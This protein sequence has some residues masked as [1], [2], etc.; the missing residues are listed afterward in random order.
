MRKL[1]NRGNNGLNWLM[2]NNLHHESQTAVKWQRQLS[3]TYKNQQGVCHGGVLSATLFK[4][5]NNRLLDRIQISGKGAR[6]G[7]I[8]IQAPTCADDMTILTNDASSLQFLDDTCKDSSDMDGYILQEIKSVVMKKDSV[9]NY[10]EGE[11]WQIGE[12]EMPVVENTTHMGILH[13]SSN[14]ERQAFESNIQKAKLTVHSLMGTGLHSEN[15]LDP[16]TAISLLQTYVYPVLYYGL[17]ILIPTGKSLNVLEIQQKKLLKQILSLSTTMADPAVYM[18]SGTLRAE[19][20]IHKRILSL[21]GN[22]TRLPEKSVKYQLA[23][24]QLEVKTFKSHSWFSA[25]K[26][27]LIQYNLPSPESLLDNPLKKLA[28]KKLFNYAINEYWTC[29]IVSQWRIYSSLKY[30]SKTYVVGKCHPAVKPYMHSN[31]GIPRI[32]GKNKVLTGTYVLQTNRVKFN[33]NEVNPICLL[34]HEEDEILQRFL[35]DCKSLEDIR[36]PIISDF[37]RQPI[38]SD[39]LRVLGD[40]YTRYSVASDYTLLQLLVDSNI[41]LQDSDSRMTSEIMTLVKSLHYHSR[42]LGQP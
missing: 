38:I 36:Q 42:R 35:T 29:Q 28:W 12:R 31:R 6:I 1:Y 25:V 16:E 21:Y 11:T 5:Y 27:I 4:V 37:L 13:L 30:L 18:L 17:E 14:Q 33:Q 26:K 34:C 22:I 32:S 20:M 8:G 24:R 41:V 7:S 39:F 9:K 19:A 15:G 3:S 23:N 40:L 2:I 10:P